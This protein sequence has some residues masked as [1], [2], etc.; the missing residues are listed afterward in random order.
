MPLGTCGV[1]CVVE[2][3]VGLVVLPQLAG[4]EARLAQASAWVGEGGT[5]RSRIAD[6]LPVQRYGSYTA[7][8]SDGGSAEGMK[9][10][11][12]SE[13]RANSSDKSLEK[14]TKCLLAVPKAELDKAK[15]ADQEHKQGQK[16]D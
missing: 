12:A 5:R 16:A 13:I 1:L 7:Q 4:A 3:L 6:S 14:L 2:L 10:Q 8:Y 11:K 15:K 9:T